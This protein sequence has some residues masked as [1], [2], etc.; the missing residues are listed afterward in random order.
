MLSEATE[1][2]SNKI[3]PE[4]KFLVIDEVHNLEAVATDALKS[5]VSLS[6]IEESLNSLDLIIRRQKNKPLSEPFVFP[7]FREISE[8]IVLN[9]GMVF[10]VLFRYL[11]SRVSQDFDNKYNQTLVEANFF[12]QEGV[13]GLSRVLD[14]LTDRIHE[15]VTHLY[16]APEALYVQMDR[17]VSTLEA[18]L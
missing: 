16:A 2:A 12:K 10:D 6:L 7:E 3:L 17:S 13:S 8:S 14:A 1:E 18:G 5:S 4:M 9:F 11:A 15:L